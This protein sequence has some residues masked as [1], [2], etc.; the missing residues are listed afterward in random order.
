MD[1]AGA[2]EAVADS[3]RIAPS[4]P[5]DG[6]DESEQQAETSDTHLTE[7]QAVLFITGRLSD[8]RRALVERHLVH[9]PSCRSLVSSVVEW[10]DS[11]RDRKVGTAW[12][13]SVIPRGV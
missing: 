13:G 4:R 12:R 11:T 5:S 1:E 8:A 10:G 3:E 9:C 2:G 7:E 6:G